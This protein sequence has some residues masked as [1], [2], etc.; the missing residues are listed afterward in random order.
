M[1]DLDYLVDTYL[2]K[3]DW[4]QSKLSA[5]FARDYFR[6][7]ISINNVVVLREDDE[8]VGYLSV[9]FLDKDQLARL[10]N[11]DDFYALDEDITDG[12]FV[13]VSNAFIEHGK[14][15]R[16]RINKLKNMMKENHKDRD[17]VGIIY[18]DGY[19]KELFSFYKKG[20]I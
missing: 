4:H 16:G 5:D 17:Y 20:E 3:E 14:R 13:F 10:I 2:F 12:D 19:H 6:K 11:G 7:L 18:Q 1:E 9:W 15:N 8:P